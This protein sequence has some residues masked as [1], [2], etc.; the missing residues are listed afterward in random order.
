MNIKKRV[1]IN[2]VLLMIVHIYVCG[3]VFIYAPN[4]F[5]L[6]PYAILIS[7]YILSERGVILEFAK[8][9]LEIQ[10]KQ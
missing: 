10:E 7:L 3:F 8:K 4:N 6:I 2:F 1:I 5:I 9:I